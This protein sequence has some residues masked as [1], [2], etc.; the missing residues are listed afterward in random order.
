M[1]RK[2]VMAEAEKSYRYILGSRRPPSEAKSLLLCVQKGCQWKRCKFCIGYASTPYFIRPVPHVL[3]DIRL[4]Q[5]FV[6]ALD[7]GSLPSPAGLSSDELEALHMAQHW[8][9]HGKSSVFLQEA[10]PL[11]LKPDDLVTILSALTSAFPSIQRVTCYGRSKSIARLSQEQLNAIREAGLNRVHI[12]LESGSDAVL[13]LMDK[14]VS[15][16]MNIRA[17]QMC[18]LAG[19]EVSENVMPGLGGV[20]LSAEHALHTADALCQIN[21][22]IILLRTLAIP[23]G[24][25]LAEEFRCGRFR[26]LSEVE[27]VQEI[28]QL[29]LHLDSR[30]TSI[31]KSDHCCNLLDLYGQLPQDRDRLLGEID[32]FLA[33]SAEDQLTFRVGKRLGLLRR[34]EDLRSGCVRGRVQDVLSAYN[35]QAENADDFSRQLTAEMF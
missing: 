18:K 30:V 13:Q 12:G 21:P 11:H 34:I 28:R 29:L 7:E 8:H 2:A 5:R 35:V 23:E 33:L 24:T 25:A 6:S 32:A 15:K 14:G 17:G 27:K 1:S 20:A 4:L 3:Q 10:D 31:L 16:E 22:D 19:I 9:K 26:D